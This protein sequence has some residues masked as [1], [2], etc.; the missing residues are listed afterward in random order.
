MHDVIKVELSECFAVV[1]RCVEGS[2]CL[3]EMKN[4]GDSSATGNSSSTSKE[5]IYKVKKVM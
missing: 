1:C 3:R 2:T 5:C 4:C